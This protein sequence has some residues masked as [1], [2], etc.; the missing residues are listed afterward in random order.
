[1]SLV[2][3]PFCLFV[4]SDP[5]LNS[6]FRSTPYGGGGQRNSSMLGLFCVGVVALDSCAKKRQISF[7][8]AIF[9]PFLSE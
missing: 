5:G 1:M 8:A 9:S 7:Q 3:G 4:A 6:F 2:G